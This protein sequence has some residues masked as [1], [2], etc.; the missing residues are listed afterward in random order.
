MIGK[1]E[2]AIATTMAFLNG[3][4]VPPPGLAQK[5]IARLE[6]WRFLGL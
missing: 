6:Y 1:H 4:P 3:A 5:I 2:R